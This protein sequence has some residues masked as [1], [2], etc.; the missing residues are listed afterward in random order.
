LYLNRA[1]AFSKINKNEEAIKD[2]NVAIVFNNEYLKAYL[3]RADCFISLGETE[4]IN[5]AIR[6]V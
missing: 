2:C 1:I 3:R 4:N 6:L 5:K